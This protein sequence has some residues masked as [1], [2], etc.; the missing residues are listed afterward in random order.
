MLLRS[1]M[2][3]RLRPQEVLA[4]HTSE[5]VSQATFDNTVYTIK[6]SHVFTFVEELRAL[7]RS[8]AEGGAGGDGGGM[9]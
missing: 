2:F 9:H 8:Y 6:R 7:I 4:E 1:S 3:I 5:D